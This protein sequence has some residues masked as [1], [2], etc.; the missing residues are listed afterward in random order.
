MNDESMQREDRDGGWQEKNEEVRME[1]EE[2]KE[3]RS[4]L[5]K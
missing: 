1:E 5:G 3:K 2:E 4:S